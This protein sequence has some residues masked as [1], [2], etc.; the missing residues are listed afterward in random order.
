[1]FFSVF[2]FLSALVLLCSGFGGAGDDTGGAGCWI[3][4]LQQAALGALVALGCGGR[5]SG[6]VGKPMVSSTCGSHACHHLWCVEGRTRWSLMPHPTQTIPSFSA[7]QGHR[8]LVLAEQPG[9]PLLIALEQCVPCWSF[10]TPSQAQLCWL[11]DPS[12]TGSECIQLYRA[13]PAAPRHISLDVKPH[14][15]AQTHP[16]ELFSATQLEGCQQHGHHSS[17]SF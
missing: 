1:M 11:Q 6:A 17:C 4:A 7:A 14:L 13:P 5:E 10:P 8:Q 16:L 2:Q 9:Q 3:P 15:L 12:P